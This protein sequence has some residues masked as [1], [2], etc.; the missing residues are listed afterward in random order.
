M[1]VKKFNLI[2]YI[3][4]LKKSLLLIDLN[5]DLSIKLS[6]ITKLSNKYIDI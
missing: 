5:N 3:I 4:I 6:K 1:L 2:N